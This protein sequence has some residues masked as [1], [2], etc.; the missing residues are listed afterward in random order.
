MQPT[1]KRAG[2]AGPA[3]AAIALAAALAPPA[4][5]QPPPAITR[6]PYLQSGS[7]GGVVVRWRT[8][9]PTDSRVRYGFD[10]ASLS[11]VEDDPRLVTDHAVALRGLAPGTTYHYAV[12]TTSLVL[13]GGDAGHFVATAPLPGTRRPTRVWVI[14]DSGTAGA[15]AAAVRDAYAA[16]GAGRR[17][18]LWLMLGD[19]AYP[20]G[21]DAQYQAAVFDMYPEIL[22]NTV[23]WPTLGNHDGVTADSA[24]QSGPYYDIFTLP[25]R[26]EAG[27]LASG[28][29][30][31]YSFDHANVHF[32]CLDSN[33]TD[34]S[35]SGA[36]LAWL[37][38]DLA[39]TSQD[40]IV[41]FWHHPPYSKGSHDSDYEIQLVEMRENVL[42][43]L[44]AAGVDLVLA[45]HSH[46]YERS[47]LLDGH[48]GPSWTFAPGMMVDAGDGRIGGDGAYRKPAAGPAPNEGAVYAVAGSSGLTDGGPLDHPAMY[49]SLNVLGSLV[50]DVEGLRLD[51]TFL[52]ASGA[53]LDTVTIL[54]GPEAPPAADFEARP[55]RGAAPLTL[56]AWDASANH[57]TAWA[58]DFDDDGTV[59]SSERHP[60]HPYGAPGLYTVRLTAT[61]E[62]GSDVAVKTGHVCVLSAAGTADADADGRPD[63]AD[64]CPC[65]PNAG[66]DDADG[67]GAGD[68][69]DDCPVAADP[70]Q[71]DADGDGAGDACDP[72]DDGD[73][74]ADAADC[75]PLSAGASGPPGEVGD[76]VRWDAWG[77]GISWLRAPG[78]AAYNV[79]RGPAGPAAPFEY[80]HACFEAASPDTR[81]G[82]PAAPA[83]GAILYY[84]VGALNACG[85]GG[86]GADSAPNPRPNPY[87]CPGAPGGDADGDGVPDLEDGCP[88]LPDDGR[89]DADLDGAGDA[90][91]NC[92]AVPNA[93][94]ADADGDGAGDACDPCTNADADG[95]GTM[96][97]VD[98]DDDGDGAPDVSDCAPLDPG[99]S[100]PPGEVQ[101]VEVGAGPAPALSW[102][103][104]GEGFRYDVV[105]GPVSALPAGGFGTAACL[106]NDVTSSAGIGSGP[107]PQPG[108][109][110]FL[111]V[112]AQNVCGAAGYGA[113]TSG[114]E[115]LPGAGCP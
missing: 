4:A 26:G 85:E 99:A 35:P 81:S 36:M 2:R 38:Q 98:L 28:T 106:V 96:D 32:V 60:A 86:L 82:D 91:D 84:L 67:D 8:D 39:A 51:G 54:K 15:G 70:S 92:P 14:G 87:P 55:R 29:E 72:D 27:G 73:G 53:V 64:N 103:A 94:Q 65:G 30:A 31:Y 74:V 49:V 111:L 69:C 3:A 9:V 52:D 22:R 37:A 112:R 101:G 21:T 59:D 80:A 12:G 57:P 115:R 68:A 42:P 24:T 88:V 93:A 23:L 7:A 105:A 75:A 19:N 48:H 110:T 46:S 20:D 44:E 100:S 107:D 90:C 58:W 45:G 33:E 47:F 10:P 108:E 104:Q 83:P 11:F 17:A 79:Y 5:A 76:T 62:S 13:A 114:A 78:G 25:A 34:R 95:D 77:S 61:N 1:W 56:R 102:T 40:W 66:Q 89:A 50:L 109:I 41:A 97:C 113:G 18:D 43:V 63:G 71:A 16:Y 6:G